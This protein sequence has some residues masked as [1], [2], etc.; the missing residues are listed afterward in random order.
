[1]DAGTGGAGA[2]AGGRGVTA[3]RRRGWQ[4]RHQR[5]D[6]SACDESKRNDRVP[7]ARWRC[8]PGCVGSEIRRRLQR[9]GQQIFD[10]EASIGNISEPAPAVLLEAPPQQCPE[11]WRRVVRQS[12][13]F[14]FASH[15]GAQRVRHGDARKRPPGR[16]HLV[17]QAT[18]CPDVASSINAVAHGLF[19]TD[20]GNGPDQHAFLRA[21]KRECEIWRAAVGTGVA[22]ELRHAKIQHLDRAGSGDL[23]V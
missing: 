8:R 19:G 7:S 16:Q 22:R 4:I 2:T 14:G 6:N 9:P 1:M 21:S 3:V 23:D 17:Q 10:V 20:V 5:C 13:P 15:D 12:V 18:E 11:R